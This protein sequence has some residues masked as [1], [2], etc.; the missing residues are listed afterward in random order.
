MYRFMNDCR[1]LLGMLWQ[2]L[3]GVRTEKKWGYQRCLILSHE[4]PI[5]EVNRLRKSTSCFHYLAL[6]IGIV[7]PFL[8]ATAQSVSPQLFNGLQWRL[9][10][11]FRG[12]RVVAVAGV[13]GDPTTFYFGSVGGGIW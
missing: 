7:V 11:P 2:N 9:I 8:S 10:G 3:C 1:S 12:G 6:A 4:N 13:P 5:G